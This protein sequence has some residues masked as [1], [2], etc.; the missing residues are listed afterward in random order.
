MWK[1]KSSLHFVII[2]CHNHFANTYKQ[3]HN[4]L[5]HSQKKINFS[6]SEFRKFK[7][8]FLYLCSKILRTKCCPNRL[9]TQI[10]VKRKGNFLFSKDIFYVINLLSEHRKKFRFLLTIHKSS[11]TFTLGVCINSQKVF[12]RHQRN[13]ILKKNHYLSIAVTTNSK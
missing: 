12:Y 6:F 7:F 2:N 9:V 3:Q 1:K 4:K 13:Q 10:V 5:N 8:C 11:H